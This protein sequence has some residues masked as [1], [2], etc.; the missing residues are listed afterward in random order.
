MLTVAEILRL[1]AAAVPTLKVIIETIRGAQAV[2]NQTSEVIDLI[3]NLSP[4]VA[5]LVA[6]F[7]TIRTQTEAQ[8]PEVWAS[9]R[10]D[11]MAAI[12]LNDELNKP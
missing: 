4:T 5:K 2:P 6:A 12:A 10:G 8:Y 9:V 7:E 1:V 11:Y 3:A